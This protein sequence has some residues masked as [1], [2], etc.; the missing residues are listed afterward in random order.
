MNWC[1]MWQFPEQFFNIK[2]ER[3]HSIEKLVGTENV[4]NIKLLQL[5]MRTDM[6]EFQAEI[7]IGIAN[8]I[9]AMKKITPVI[10]KS[11]H[12]PL[13][14]TEMRDILLAYQAKAKSFLPDYI[15]EQIMDNVLDDTIWGFGQAISFVRTHGNKCNVQTC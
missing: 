3:L 14:K 10:E 13:S 9:K 5:H 11:I 7:E 12:S 8:M 1:G 4:S 15:L 2:I 6:K